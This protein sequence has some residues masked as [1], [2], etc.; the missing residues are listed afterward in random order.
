MQEELFVRI[1]RWK[2]HRIRHSKIISFDCNDQGREEMVAT[3]KQ[4]WLVVN[5][6][7]S[8][9]WILLRSFR[10]VSIQSTLNN[11]T[12]QPVAEAV[13]PLTTP[14]LRAKV[15]NEATIQ[16]LCAANNP[17]V[18]KLN[19]N[20]ENYFRS[21][22]NNHQSTNHESD[23]LVGACSIS[24]YFYV[25]KERKSWRFLFYADNTGNYEE[26]MELNGMGKEIIN[27]ADSSNKSHNYL[28]DVVP[29]K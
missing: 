6:A 18:K 24:I 21:A 19:G 27:M 5:S 16:G 20:K 22:L 17:R 15:K 3:F 26:W 12:L 11:S 28:L 2:S 25:W 13:H 8:I 7:H 1:K 4:W 10:V 14:R 29:L 9:V 23:I